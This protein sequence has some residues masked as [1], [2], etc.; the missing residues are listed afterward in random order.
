MTIDAL[1]SEALKLEKELEKRQK[2]IK[3]GT[4]KPVHFTEV[5]AKI[6]AKYGF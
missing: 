5:E 4:V 6:R 2:S 3:N 1:K